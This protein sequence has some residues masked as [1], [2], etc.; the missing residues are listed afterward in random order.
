MYDAFNK[1]IT[2]MVESGLANM[3]VRKFANPYQ[4]EKAK[5]GPDV[6]TLN[7]LGFAFKAWLVF[8]VVSLLCFLVEFLPM[9][10]ARLVVNRLER[11]QISVGMFLRQ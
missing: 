9:F 2:Q 4:I 5:K 11:T 8:L 10:L 1:K 6:L 3:F 7:H